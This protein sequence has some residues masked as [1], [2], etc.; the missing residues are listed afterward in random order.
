ME[1]KVLGPGCP[2]C[3]AL[4]KATR[5]AI[6]DLEIEADFEYVTEIGRIADYGVFMTPALLVNGEVKLAGRT[7]SKEEIKRLIK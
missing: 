4:E 7:A 5:E 1:I 6:D 3:H 2:K